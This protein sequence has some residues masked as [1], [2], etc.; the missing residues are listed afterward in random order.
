MY[1]DARFFVFFVTVAFIIIVPMSHGEAQDEHT[2][3]HIVGKG[4]HHVETFAADE[5][6]ELR[7]QFEAV[8]EHDFFQIAIYEVSA[9]R[10]KLMIADITQEGPGSGTTRQHGTGHFELDVM[11]LGAWTITVVQIP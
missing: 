9:R 5:K 1:V 11:A 4:P 3:L 2:V 6:W 8:L 7:W 10:P